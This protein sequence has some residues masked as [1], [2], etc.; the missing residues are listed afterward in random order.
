MIVDEHL[1]HLRELPS[2]PNQPEL[3]LYVEIGNRNTNG[4]E[5]GRHR[6]EQCQFPMN[7]EC[8]LLEEERLVK[9]SDVLVEFATQREQRIELHASLPTG[10]RLARL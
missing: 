1:G 2:L 9:R 3:A 8:R 6:L 4:R 7:V 10:V 5:D